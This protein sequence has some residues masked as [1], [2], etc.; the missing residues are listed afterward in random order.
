M[1][2]RVDH[3]RAERDDRRLHRIP[4]A[5]DLAW[6]AQQGVAASGD[7][8]RRDRNRD[9]VVGTRAQHLDAGPLAAG[10]VD[11]QQVAIGLAAQ[12]LVER[13]VVGTV[14][15]RVDDQHVR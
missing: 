7:L 6:P 3:E 8:V 4:V 12:A 2:T 13:T 1:A 10:R 5:A 11:A 9:G 14:H 15:R